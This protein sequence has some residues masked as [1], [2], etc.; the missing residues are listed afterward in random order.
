MPF[1]AVAAFEVRTGAVRCV[2]GMFSRIPAVETLK[3]V[4]QEVH[5]ASW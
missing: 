1:V 5:C 2:V 3:Q 4:L